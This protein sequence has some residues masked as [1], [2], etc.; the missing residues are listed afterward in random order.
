MDNKEFGKI[1]LGW[2]KKGVHPPV[3]L[4][5]KRTKT[6]GINQQIKFYEM[7]VQTLNQNANRIISNYEAPALSQ[8]SSEVV[9]E[10][11]PTV[12]GKAFWREGDRINLVNK[13][14]DQEEVG[15]VL[16]AYHF[17]GETVSTSK[18]MKQLMQE[19]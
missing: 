19:V 7:G 4:Y 17:Q 11:K 12:I 1:Y 10:L 2:L 6:K 13:L 9:E 3:E 16:N 18:A 8:I 15:K 14:L 5:E